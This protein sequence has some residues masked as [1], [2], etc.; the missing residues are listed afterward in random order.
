MEKY[1]YKGKEEQAVLNEALKDLGVTIDDVL[2]KTS[3]EKGC[4]FSGKKVVIEI[5]KLE[6]IASFGKKILE[7][8]LKGFNLEGNIEKQIRNKQISYRIHSNN[9]GI[10][11]GKNGKV[12][13]SIQIYLKQS[14]SS[15]TGMY[16]NVILD[17]ENYKEKQN[18]F[19]ERDVKKIARQVTLTKVDVKLDPMNS[20]Q[21]RIVHNALSKFDYIKTES[22]G[23]EPNR[24]VVIKYK[25]KNEE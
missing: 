5:V 2:T 18:Y 6:D 22:I 16:I 21:R 3:E 4:L 12:L 11:I 25:E 9:N 17:V 1:V 7:D 19:L 8:I 13:S 23:T 20:F 24:C 10:L 14:I 15:Q